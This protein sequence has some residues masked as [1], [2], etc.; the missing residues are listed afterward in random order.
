MIRTGHFCRYTTSRGNVYVIEMITGAATRANTLYITN[1]THSLSCMFISIFYMFRAATCSSSG[2]LLYHCDTRFMSLCVADRLICRL[3][4][5]PDGLCDVTCRET[6]VAWV[7]STCCG[8]P[9]AYHQE[10]YCIIAGP[11]LCHSV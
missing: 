8:Q 3:T 4:C 1:L 9:C 10:N 5:I 11:G 2:E 7:F 6:A